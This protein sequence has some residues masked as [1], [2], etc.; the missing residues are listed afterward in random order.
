MKALREMAIKHPDVRTA[1]VD[2]V[3]TPIALITE[4]FSRLKWNQQDLQV[5]DSVDYDLDF[6]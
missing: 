2:S 3:Q 6:T 4:M 5:C 1:W